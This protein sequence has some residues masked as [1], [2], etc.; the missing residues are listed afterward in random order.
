MFHFFPLVCLSLTLWTSCFGDEKALQRAE[1]LLREVQAQP[2]AHSWRGATIESPRLVSQKPDLAY[3]T[4]LPP[5]WYARIAGPQNHRG[6]LMWAQGE[7]SRLLEFALDDGF[8]FA[9]K[10]VKV[11]AGVPP[12]QQF[13]IDT[14]A[15]RPVASGCV[16]TAGASVI[17][18]WRKNGFPE[19]GGTAQV[20]P[21]EVT[22]RLRSKLK[23]AL[24]R[25]TDGFAQNR[26]DLAGAFPGDL[27]QA[28]RRDA[29][30][31]G[32]ALETRFEK[33]TLK[34]FEEEISAGRPTLLS[35]TV[36]L[37]SQP[38]LSWNHE[39]VGVG[40]LRIK[41]QELVGVIDNFYPTKDSNTVR[42]ISKEAF[43]S[44][45]ALRPSQKN[46]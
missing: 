21:Q 42:W 2:W 28:L 9:G 25:N 34:V 4:G 20:T 12:I 18:F 8:Q 23:M 10:E 26:M 37:P 32:V 7:K 40:V 14:Q 38:E 31:F 24:F 46:Q 17:C 19:W 36:R 16:P 35:C 5:V 45:I 3:P 13:P 43:R 6:Y 22:L 29:E 1:Q 44:L 41:E 39:V 30:A 27:V 33:F 15:Q 11:I